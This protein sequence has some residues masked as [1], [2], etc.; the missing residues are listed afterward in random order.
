MLF[1]S[2]K[3]K[4]TALLLT[5]LTSLNVTANSVDN[6]QLGYGKTVSLQQ[7]VYSGCESHQSCGQYVSSAYTPFLG[8]WKGAIPM[9]NHV[10]PMSLEFS[11]EN[12][13]LKFQYDF[14]GMSTR[15]DKLKSTQMFAI[16]Q[17]FADSIITIPEEGITISNL[18]ADDGDLVADVYWLGRTFKITFRKDEEQLDQPVAK[19]SHQEKMSV[20][21]LLFDNVDVLDWAGPLEVMTHSHAFNVFTVA[22]EMQ[23]ILGGAYKVMPD[24]TF[25]TMPEADIVIVPGGDVAPLFTDHESMAWIKEQSLN[26]DYLMSVCN[27][28]TL[29]AA[30]GELSGMQATTHQSWMNWLDELSIEHKFDV[31][32]SAR[33]VDNGKIITTA[34][35]SSGIDGALHLVAKIKGFKHAQMT[36]SM[37]E[38]EWKPTVK[39]DY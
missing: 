6:V 2:K 10:H 33:F 27:A 30:A 34:G 17:D 14:R 31:D 20:A 24:H 7:S 38:Y 1:T 11:I 12:E 28:A 13:K 39:Y 35:V 16:E 29:L 4:S 19:Q 3:I 5:A 26:A 25:S 37:L 18:S 22:K 32:D 8:N 15:S 9:G 36:A 23:P 21:I